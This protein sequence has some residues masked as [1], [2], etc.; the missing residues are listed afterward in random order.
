MESNEYLLRLIRLARQL[1]HLDFFTGEGPFTKTEFRLLKEVIAERKN[2]KSIIS[3][4]LS[5][6]LGVTRSAISQVVTKLERRDIVRRTPSQ[7]DRKI[8][9]VCLSDHA[10]SVYDAQCRAVNEMMERVTGEFGKDR[11][12]R[13]FSELEELYKIFDRVRKSSDCPKAE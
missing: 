8:A 11:M 4:E 10:A 1:E 13:L 2:G 3:S 7:T 6:R 9:Y 12:E 5:R